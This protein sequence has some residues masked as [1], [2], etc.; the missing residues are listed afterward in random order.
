MC[1]GADNKDPCAPTGERKGEQEQECQHKAAES[2][3]SKAAKRAEKTRRTFVTPWAAL[4]IKA[5]RALVD[6]SWRRQRQT[7]TNSKI[8]KRKLLAHILL[9]RSGH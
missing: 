1:H 8:P 2:C 9:W 7:K 3:L 4:H 5:L 6:E